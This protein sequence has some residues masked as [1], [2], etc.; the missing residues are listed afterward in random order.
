[1]QRFVGAAAGSFA[2]IEP[3]GEIIARLFGLAFGGFQFAHALVDLPPCIGGSV[4][5]ALQFF[6]EPAQRFLDLFLP[7]LRG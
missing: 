7:L 5:L 4:E 3:A 1:M 2:L 6:A